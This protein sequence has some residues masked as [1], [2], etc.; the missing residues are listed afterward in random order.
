MLSLVSRK[1]EHFHGIAG[2]AGDSRGQQADSRQKVGGAFGNTGVH[3]TPKQPEWLWNQKDAVAC[4]ISK[5]S[6]RHSHLDG[7]RLLARVER[8]QQITWLKAKHN[9]RYEKKKC[10][11]SMKKQ[12]NLLCFLCVVPSFSARLELT[13]WTWWSTPRR[14]QPVSARLLLGLKV[15]I[16]IPSKT[17]F[18]NNCGYDI[19]SR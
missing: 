14:D 8:F 12:R 13:V 1:A 9:Y 6:W 11:R 16:T 19:G 7:S 3:Q 10:D 18:L 2:T 5:T 15:C 17:T 4:S